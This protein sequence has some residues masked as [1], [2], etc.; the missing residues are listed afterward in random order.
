MFLISIQELR[1]WIGNGKVEMA[2]CVEKLRISDVVIFR[3]EPMIPKSQMRFTMRL[4]ELSHERQ[5]ANLAEPLASENWS[6]CT[7]KNS[8]DFAKNGVFQQYGRIPDLRCK[9]ETSALFL[10]KQTF[11]SF[12]SSEKTIHLELHTINELL[13][14]VDGI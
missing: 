10:L 8:T 11:A 1:G 13:S 14:C 9:R 7:N 6:H 3:K 2:D 4:S 5:K 12:L